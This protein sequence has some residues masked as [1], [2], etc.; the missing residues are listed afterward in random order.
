MEVEEP[1]NED[2][3]IGQ[4]QLTY[5]DADSKEESETEVQDLLETM[6]ENAEPAANT[7]KHKGGK[8]NLKA[9]KTFTGG[10]DDVGRFIRSVKNFIV[11]NKK[12]FGSDHTKAV[13]WT[14]SYME[15]PDVDHW[16][17]N[18]EE[19]HNETNMPMIEAFLEEVKTHFTP[20]DKPGDALHLLKTEKMQKVKTAEHFVDRF[21]SYIC[22]S[23]I[24]D[25]ITI[26]DYF[27]NTIIMKIQ[28]KFL[29]SEKFPATP[30]EW[31]EK[32]IKLDTNYVGHQLSQRSYITQVQEGPRPQEAN[33]EQQ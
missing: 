21:K 19:S 25:D 30:A 23:G 24:K 11:F 17:E 33:T 3:E 13:L 14:L 26:M 18:W 28:E 1:R 31:Y 7:T 22:D 32:A 29:Y 4:E 2:T 6:A 20:N 9:P 5:H 16:K 12:Q 8:I 27:Q 10:K 15:G